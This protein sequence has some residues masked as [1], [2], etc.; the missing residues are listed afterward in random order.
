MVNKRL[1]SNPASLQL[2]LGFFGALVSSFCACLLLR[3]LATERC[4][5]R[6]RLQVGV[7]TV[8]TFVPRSH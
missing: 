4:F 8:V 7:N 3:L 2:G 6:V 5:R 1:K